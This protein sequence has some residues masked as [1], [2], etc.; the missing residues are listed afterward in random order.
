LRVDVGNPDEVMRDVPETL[1]MVAGSLAAAAG[2]DDG[3]HERCACSI[4]S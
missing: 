1:S 3:R 2:Q 4:D